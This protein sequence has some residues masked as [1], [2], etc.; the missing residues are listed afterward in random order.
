MLGV[1]WHVCELKAFPA[2]VVTSEQLNKVAR[3]QLNNWNCGLEPFSMY[4]YYVYNSVFFP[5]SLFFFRTEK[6]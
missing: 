6:N 2:K 3:I 4:V 1:F 5:K